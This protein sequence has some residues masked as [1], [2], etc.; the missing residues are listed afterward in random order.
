MRKMH[1]QTTLKLRI[2]LCVFIYPKHKP[3]LLVHLIVFII[4]CNFAT[5]ISLKNL[6]LRVKYKYILPIKENYTCVHIYTII[7]LKI[8]FE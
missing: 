3:I 6:E 8:S 2:Q 1:G 5:L 4:C 7:L